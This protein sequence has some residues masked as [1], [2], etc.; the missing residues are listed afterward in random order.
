MSAVEII[1]DFTVPAAKLPYADEIAALAKATKEHGDK[2]VIKL[3]LPYKHIEDEGVWRVT[4][5]EQGKLQA[6]ARA[7]GFS[8]RAV[9][10]NE[11]KAK[12]IVTRFY[13]LG[14]KTERKSAE[15]AKV[16]SDAAAS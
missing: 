14:N 10:D 9:H 8:A 7:A 1:T 11:D 16:E 13:K 3:E 6:A 5:T 4:L 2:A 12:G 15:D